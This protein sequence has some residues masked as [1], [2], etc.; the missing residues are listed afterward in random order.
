MGSSAIAVFSDVHSNLEALDAVL[1]DM[2]ALGIVNRICLGDLVGYG[3]S[4]RSCLDRARSLRCPILKGNHDWATSGDYSLKGWSDVARHGIAWSRFKLSAAQKQ[5]LA[6]LPLTLRTADCEYVHASLHK[7]DEWNYILT[8]AD[9]A[10]HFGKQNTRI[11]FCGHTHLPMVVEK[12]RGRLVSLAA[13]S[14]RVKLNPSRRYLANVGSVGQPR[15]GYPEACYVLY[16]PL[17]FTL[18]FRRI[19]YDIGK[20][21]RKILRAR[22]PTFLAD[23][24]EQGV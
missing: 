12:H 17:D 20:T 4:P 10:Q 6:A 1:A 11:S 2:A 23:R 21:R 3:P 18:E 8:E 15:D 24:L 14:G 22:L 9:A 5:F 19:P 13:Q 16:Q 7:P